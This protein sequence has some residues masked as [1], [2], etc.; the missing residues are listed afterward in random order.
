MSAERRAARRA[1]RGLCLAAAA[2]IA[3]AFPI[4]NFDNT[5]RVG[6]ALVTKKT[7]CADGVRPSDPNHPFDAIVVP[8]AGVD[9]APDG[10]HIPTDDGQTRLKATAVAFSKGVAPRIIL[11]DGKGN[12]GTSEAYLRGLIGGSKIPNGAILVEGNSTNTATNMEE[13]RKIVDEHQVKRVAMVTNNYHVPRAVLLSCANGIPTSPLPA[14]DLLTEESRG[15]PTAILLKERLAILSQLWD[16][17]GKIQT[18]LG[19]LKQN[20]FWLKK[21]ILSK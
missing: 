3:L 20:N 19:K 8:G 15:I 6:E 14:E 17:K 4:G 1:T 13:L 16:P 12:L 21:S 9:L 10:S 7:G 11:L 18:L 2:A 5:M